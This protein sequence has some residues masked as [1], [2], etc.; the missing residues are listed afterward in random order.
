MT[1]K[2]MKI[3]NCCN[4]SQNVESDNAGY[5]VKRYLGSLIASSYYIYRGVGEGS[6]ESGKDNKTVK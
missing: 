3:F 2:W 4:F 5:Q 6:D 1:I